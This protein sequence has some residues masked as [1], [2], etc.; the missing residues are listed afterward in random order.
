MQRAQFFLYRS[1]LFIASGCTQRIRIWIWGRSKFTR[2][3]ELTQLLLHCA[4]PHCNWVRTT[5]WELRDTSSSTTFWVGTECKRWSLTAWFALR[6]C[7][8]LG[9]AIWAP[10]D[11][12][13]KLFSVKE[14]SSSEKSSFSHRRGIVTQLE[15]YTVCWLYLRDFQKWGGHL[16][17]LGTFRS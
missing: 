1:S 9:K 16:W 5:S 11:E 7:F 8:T 2:H 3:D 12:K 17:Q 10:G 6:M 4:T 14:S 15:G 13:S